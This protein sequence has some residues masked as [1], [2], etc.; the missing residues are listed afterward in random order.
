MQEGVLRNFTKFT[1]KHL[2]QSLVLHIWEMFQS[3]HLH[4]VGSY[5]F[6]FRLKHL[7]LFGLLSSGGTIFQTFEAKY[8]KEFHP[9]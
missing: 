5:F 1:G 9:K 7:K 3:F 4:C 8:C 2:H 6:N